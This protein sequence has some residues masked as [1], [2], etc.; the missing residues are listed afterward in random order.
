M[1]GY[2][3]EERKTIGDDAVLDVARSQIEELGFLARGEGVELR[4]FERSA[5]T[6]RGKRGAERNGIGGSLNGGENGGGAQISI[7]G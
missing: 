1:A 3:F 7:A 4:R 2:L 6:E 5:A